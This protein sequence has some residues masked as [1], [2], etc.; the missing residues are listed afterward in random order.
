MSLN[1][2]TAQVM[3]LLVVFA[4]ETSVLNATSSD[5]LID[6]LVKKGVLTKQEAEEVRADLLSEAMGPPEEKITLKGDSYITK[7]TL[8]GDARLRFQW[9]NAQEE[10]PTFDANGE[11]E[12]RFRYRYR[13]RLG[14]EYQ[15]LDDFKAGVRLETSES[16]DSTNVD[17]GGYFDKTGD[18]VYIG[19]AYLEYENEDIFDLGLVDYF[20][21]TVGK[22]TFIKRFMMQKAWWDGDINPEG[23]S[24]QLGWEDVYIDGLNLTLRSGAYVVSDEDDRVRGSE[25]GD[26]FLFVEQAEFAYSWQPKTGI[27]FA[28][29]FMF[30]SNGHFT[31]PEDAG[32]PDNENAYASVGD[33]YVFFMPVELTWN[34]LGYPQMLYGT[35]GVNFQDE[36][37]ATNFGANAQSEGH[38]QFFNI[39]YQWGKA[40]KKG[41]WQIG[42]EYRYY[43]A[44]AYSPNLSDSDFAKNATNQHGIVFKVKY[45]MTDYLYLAGTYFHSNAI[46]GTAGA[47]GFN[48][49]AGSEFS[50]VDL[51]QIDLNWKY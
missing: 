11:D 32:T 26:G 15:F 45:A 14:A 34:M 12:N 50:Q 35:Y 38:N 27:K 21:F 49:F 36:T 17:F 29:S 23:L 42:A 3:G 10:G 1:K 40:K 6:I 37:T 9:E 20:N 47:N 5:A 25:D 2:V 43:G 33:Y 24:A 18:D 22:Q 31:N 19:L 28:P 30:E 4:L 51:L 7:F 39:G 41:S 44:F 16:S 13:L 8:Y 48:E 46:D